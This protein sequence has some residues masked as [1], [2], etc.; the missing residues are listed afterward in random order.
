MS[1]NIANAE[2]HNQKDQSNTPHTP[3]VSPHSPLRLTQSLHNLISRAC[4]N[5]PARTP[6]RASRRPH[7]SPSHRPAH[8]R[9]ARSS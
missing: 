2:N 1:K 9:C 5:V 8:E 7:A 4:I 3:Q 6:V